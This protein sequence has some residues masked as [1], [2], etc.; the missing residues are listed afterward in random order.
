MGHLRMRRQGLQS[1]KEK[2][3]CI[4]LEY[5]ITTNV[6]YCTTMKPSTTKEWNIYSDL[7]GCFPTTSSRGNK[8]IYVMYVYDY[9]CILTTSMKNRSDKDMIISFTSLTEDLKIR[10]IHPGFHFT[11]N[12]ASTALK[13]NMRTMN[14]KYQLVPP[15]N[16]RAKI[17]KRVIQ[18]FKNHFLAVLF[19]V[20]K[21]FH[22]Q[23]WYRL[24]QQATIS[25]NLIRQS[26]TLP[27]IS[28]YNHIFR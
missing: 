9:N 12:E 24:L 2:P 4:E 28:L 27:H 3:P 22:L 18:T 26:R 13:L 25:L 19:Y 20:D 11:D 15:S 8:Y 6:V 5:N 10:G 16:H 21:D 1:N 7:C 14:I 17:A 23:L